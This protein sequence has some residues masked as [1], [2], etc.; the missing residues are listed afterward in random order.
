[1]L[2]HK[3]SLT[4]I[5]LSCLILG[6]C[7]Q[8]L[9]TVKDDQGNITEKYAVNDQNQKHGSYESYINNTLIEKANY[10]NGKLDGLR[11]LFHTN[12]AV[13]IEEQYQNDLMIGVYKNYD[14][15]GKLI[16]EAPYENGVMEGMLKTY[17]PD[18]TLKEEV[19]MVNNEENGAFTEYHSNGQIKWKGQF[20][21]GDN[22]FGLLQEF[23]E[24]GT[25][26]K[27]MECDSLAVCKT[28][29]TINKG[30]INP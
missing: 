22:E 1:M 10:Q 3:I 20:L 24:A 30:D 9:I 16:L 11:Q 15:K 13:E 28:I 12:G 26:I 4:S 2:I 17:Y 23:N 5:I 8:N 25:L 14:H 19:T 27:K 29:W 18:G 21:N 6:S 7:K